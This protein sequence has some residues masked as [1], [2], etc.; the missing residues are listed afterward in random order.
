MDPRAF[1]FLLTPRGQALLEELTDT[2]ITPQNHLALASGLRKEV[3]SE[4]AHALLETALL[5]QRAAGKFSRASAMYFTRAALEQ[6][7][8]EAVSRYRAQR[9]ARAGL[10]TVAD[11]G[12]GI[13]G[14]SVSLAEQALVLGLDRDRL[15]LRM[16]RENVRA[17]RRTA[18]F[19]PLLADLRQLPPLPVDAFFC[20]PGRRD[21]RGRRH[22]SVHDYNPPLL[23]LLET[24]LPRVPRAAVKVS[25]GIDYDEIP[26]GAET[27]F[28]SVDGQVKEGILWFGDLRRGVQRQAT[29]LPSGATLSD[30][31]KTSAPVPLRRPQAFLYEPDGAVIRA[32]LVETLAQRLRA[33]KID[34]D[35]AYLTSKEA[36]QTPF[37][38]CFA[39]EEAL[40][41]QL[42]RL[43]KTL[44][45]RGIGRVTVKIRGS[46][47]APAELQRRL[48]LDGEQEAIVFLTHVQGEPYALIGRE[49]K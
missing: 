16:A 29:L 7:S 32:H 17:Y 19:Q 49:I 13:G 2:P 38:R 24:W 6:A 28:V 5:R 12:C 8:H 37:A 11:L 9:M 41:F 30:A 26:A 14:D 47:I 44:R 34:E 43:R 46:P 39:I 4:E 45:Q 15:R 36:M 22:Y 3:S 21:E 42:K 35:I 10:Q 31:Q 27:E 18:R 25:P 20:D 33:A 48:R 1:A 23:P 40:P